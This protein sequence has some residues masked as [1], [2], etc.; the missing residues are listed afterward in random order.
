[1]QRADD[2]RLLRV[3]LLYGRSQWVYHAR[4]GEMALVHGNGATGVA[5][6]RFDS[7]LQLL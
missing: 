1:M 7:I 3:Y 6:F 2:Y 4:L 5:R